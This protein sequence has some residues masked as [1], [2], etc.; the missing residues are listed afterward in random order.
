[1]PEPCNHKCK[2][3]PWRQRVTLLLVVYLAAGHNSKD[4]L[5]WAHEIVKLLEMVVNIFK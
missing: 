1:M 2:C 3:S 5:V 4:I